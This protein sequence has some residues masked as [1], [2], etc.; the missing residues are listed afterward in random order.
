[1]PLLSAKDDVEKVSIARRAESYEDA[2]QRRLLPLARGTR[3]RCPHCGAENTDNRRFCTECGTALLTLCQSCGAHNPLNAKF[4]GACGKSLAAPMG[5]DTERPHTPPPELRQATMLFADLC[6]FTHL[7]HQLDPEATHGL[8]DRFF[9]AVD[10]VVMR[11]G[12]SIEKHPGDAVMAVFGAPI[13]HDNDPERAV[14]AAL[15]IHE[16]MTAL[17]EELG[18]SLQV[19]I[20][21]ACGRVLAS[22]IGSR[23]HHEYSVTG[24][25]ANLA[26]RLQDAAGPCET[27]VPD[28]VYR[29]VAN[30]VEVDDAGQVKIK[31]VER[32]IRV[33]KVRKLRVDLARVPQTPFVGRSVELAQFAAVI[34]A[35]REAGNGYVIFVRGDAGIGK[36]RLVEEF[37]SIA[38]QAGF[39]CH[40]GLVLDFGVG[41]G[42]DAIR[43][44]IRSL[45]GLPSGSGKEARQAAAD[46][47][48]ADGFLQPDQRVFL[49][50]LLDLSQPIAMR[51]L[52]D[53]MDDPTRMRGKQTVVAALIR[54]AG[55]RQPVLLTIEDI[56]WADA[57][58]LAYLVGIAPAVRGCP[59]ILIMTSRIDGDPIDRGW[60]AAAQEAPLITIDLGPLRAEDALA[61]ATSILAGNTG[62]AERYVARAAGNP[63]FLEQLLRHDE[64][65]TESGVPS[66]IQRLVQARV[67]QLEATDKAA[68]QAAS[69]LGQRFRHEDLSHVLG[70]P[71]YTPER[72][73]AHL[74]IRPEGEGFLFAHALIRDA[75]Y[76]TI[77]KLRRRE[78]HRRAAEWFAERDP[79]LHAEHLDRAD[80]QAAA[81]AYLSAARSQAAA[82]RYETALR[83]VER[84][85]AL[86]SDRAD[87]FVLECFH[88]DILRDLGAMPDAARAYE[89]ALDAAS[90]D[91]DRCRAWIGCAS[92]KRVT[93]DLDGAFTDLQRAEA[94]AV[95]Q[96]LIAE[97]A[98]IHFLRGNLYFP[99]GDIDGCL[100]EHDRS[101]EL[102]SQLGMVELEAQ[103]L[104]G[105]GDAEYM[106]GRMISAHNRL[107]SCVELCRRY[108]F[109]RIEVANSAQIAHSMLYFC[110]QQEALEA[111]HA[112]AQAAAKVGHQ[113]AELN[114]R[115][116]IIFA[117]YAL[118]RLD[119]CREE[120]AKVEALVHRLGA[121]RFE[122]SYLIY[123]AR[124]ALAEGQQSQ[125]IPLLQ[126]ALDVGQRT[127]MGFH[128]PQILAVLA[129]ALDEA[130]ARRRALAEGEAVIRRGCVGHN[131]LWF[132]PDAIETALD[133]CDYDEA[134]RY[135]AAL[136]GYTRPEPLPWAEFFIARGRVL[137]AYGRDKRDDETLRE[138]RRLRG[139]ADR[140]GLN[141][142]LPALD[143]AL[144]G[145]DSGSRG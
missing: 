2:W 79:V 7:S 42:Q 16:A 103:A 102:A 30:L 111:G 115:L 129:L 106:R 70:R 24:D 64:E 49:N 21:I 20:G 110:P 101:L 38:R 77:L 43:A 13:A 89:R 124:A 14:R 59:A 145:A 93:D 29:A 68:I 23:H 123:V 130:N 84:G 138:L 18:L 9:E 99:R 60:R 134:E 87:R 27:L 55:R 8:L 15:G 73:V 12:G 28:V 107:R 96:R 56:H 34:T 66:T 95:K 44:L 126:R 67:D 53:A 47:A 17:S 135:A 74:L 78:L 61:L 36:T 46:A 94:V 63:L 121:W 133:L 104:G 139:D 105:L 22:G 80:D 142:A 82:Y 75:V 86:A 62:L 140:L 51:A 85:L 144:A 117:L 58:T 137:A 48:M 98:R 45:L 19:H 3:M 132:Y 143:Q 31:G 91:A 32:P 57:P 4:C 25:A 71:E 10:E 109:G 120:A 37:R 76:A 6:R 33:W 119:A 88:G 83:L 50:D 125:A 35:A 54:D 1:M 65:V 131:Q 141:M 52:Y 136:E 127:G 81:C 128:G 100:H 116:A 118:L 97:R 108:G 39:A 5:S 112:A 72:L 11:Y 69:V 114:A 90:D 41:K 92:V 26:S 40:T 113:R 122:Q